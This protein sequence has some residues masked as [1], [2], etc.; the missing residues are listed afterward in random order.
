MNKKEDLKLVFDFIADFLRE[1]KDSPVKMSQPKESS[2]VDGGGKISMPMSKPKTETAKLAVESSDVRTHH[3]LDLMDKIEN[4][5]REKAIINQVLATQKRNFDQELSRIREEEIA[6]VLKERDEEI[7]NEKAT[8]EFI[9][10]A[11][12]SVGQI[13]IKEDKLSTDKAP[14]KLFDKLQEIK[15]K[16]E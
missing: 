6:R 16:I 2:I 11:G 10:V 9:P 4:K 1:T 13:I 8:K 3:I 5:D 12:S 14:T 15:E 7:A